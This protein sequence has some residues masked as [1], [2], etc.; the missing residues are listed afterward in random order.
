MAAPWANVMWLFATGSGEITTGDL[1]TLADALHTEYG[2]AFAPLLSQE[3]SLDHTKVDLWFDGDQLQGDNSESVVGVQPVDPFPAQVACCISWQ[4]AV[5]YRGGHPRT[6][7]AGVGVDEANNNT[8]W[9]PSFIGFMTT[10]ANLFHAGVEAIGPI[11][12][13]ISSI[14]HGVVSFQSAKQWRTPPLFRRIAGGTVDTRIDTQ[15]RRLG[16]DR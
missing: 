12:S 14:E 5:H 2:D 1:N 3:W 6:Y 16:R 15:R 7:I 4:L 10:Q 9:Q 8:T 11:G 13:G